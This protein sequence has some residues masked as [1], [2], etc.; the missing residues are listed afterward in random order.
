MKP[1]PITPALI[2]CIEP[3][4]HSRDPRPA[5]RGRQACLVSAADGMAESA[6]KAFLWLVTCPIGRGPAP[7][8]KED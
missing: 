8:E 3:R 4:P 1:V 2:V 7:V 5:S 6:A